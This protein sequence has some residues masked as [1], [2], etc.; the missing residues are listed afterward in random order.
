MQLT[1]NH[2][3]FDPNWSPNGQMIAFISLEN[4]YMS[5]LSVI[6]ADGS[7]QRVLA[8]SISAN[9]P[10][11]S[12]DGEKLVFVSP[13]DELGGQDIYTINADGSDLMLIIEPST[14]FYTHP[15]WLSENE[16]LVLGDQTGEV[17]SA[18]FGPSLS[19]YRLSLQEQTWEELAYVGGFV[20]N[21]SVSPD[22]NYVVFDYGSGVF[23]ALE[24]VSINSNASVVLFESFND[25]GIYASDANWSPDGKELVFLFQSEDTNILRLAIYTV[26]T[27]QIR[28]IDGVNPVENGLS[29][30]PQFPN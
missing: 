2:G 5:R 24:M 16:L 27:Q 1:Q 4:D 10:D 13:N 6:N 7:N 30:Q 8:P 28:F 20:S 19:L 14:D 25:T 22:R 17:V 29:W 15:I 12:P 18:D 21:L 11:W 23:S 9:N 26:D 3:S